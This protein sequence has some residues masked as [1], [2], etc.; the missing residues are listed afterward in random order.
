MLFDLDKIYRI[1]I[2]SQHKVSETRQIYW[3]TKTIV[4]L[5]PKTM[6]PLIT[7]E[8]FVKVNPL[9]LPPAL[10]YDG[11]PVKQEPGETTIKPTFQTPTKLSIS[12]KQSG[13]VPRPS[14]KSARIS[15]RPT[16]NY[17]G[18][19]AKATSSE[20][21]D[22][23]PTTYNQAIKSSLKDKW[24]LAMDDEINALKKNQTFEVIDKPIGRNI[25][26]SKIGRAHV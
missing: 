14:R 1:Y 22:E 20:I 6:E 9:S 21:L 2:P 18:Q 19:Q 3:T 5:G 15:N 10:T 8:T 13:E 7:D 23:D 4:P 25:V 17:K 16:P 24:I 26:G 12:D 11:K